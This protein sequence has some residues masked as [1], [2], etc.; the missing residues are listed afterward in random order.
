[1]RH[2]SRFNRRTLFGA[3]LAGALA[4]AGTSALAQ[5][6]AWPTKPVKLVVP[7]APGGVSDNVARLLA[8]HLQ[9]R[10]GQSVVVENRPGVSGIPGTQAVARA[11]ADG[12]TLMGG[13]ITTHAVNPFF[14]KAL[15]YDPVKDFTPINLVGTVSN[16][17]VVS[18]ASRFNSV[19]EIIDE[20]KAK[21]DS[22]TYGT[23]GAGT[24]Q[25]LSGQLFQ[26]ITNTR[27]RQ[28]AYKGGGQAMTDLVG[29]QIDMVFE[30]VAA[31]RPMIDG[32]RVKVLGLTSRTRL[33]GLPGVQ[34]LAEL[35]V[36]QFEM[37]S[38]QGVFAPA[39]VPRPI[40]ER[41]GRE[42]AAIVAM[43]AVQDKLRTLG[44]EPDGRG[45]DAFAE[46]QRAEIA[47][48]GKVIK[49]AGIQAD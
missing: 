18:S 4:L 9:E 6:T 12:Y 21:P 5:A 29:G 35:G 43:P 30:T 3:T 31:A 13:T 42:I 39:G 10:L 34:P 28:I 33:P 36:P 17:L 14:T 32:K 8:Q 27:L 41:L 37:Q 47:K 2:A 11:P 16:V 7:F 49:D 44:V 19:Q 23:A 45:S 38:W 24:S 48:W 46:F 20:L 1:M 26:S 22:L 15:G 40:V 25:H